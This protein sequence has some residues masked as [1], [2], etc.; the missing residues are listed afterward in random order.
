MTYHAYS[1]I[2]LLPYSS[3]DDI[4]ADNLAELRDLGF[5]MA[6]EIQNVHGKRYRYGEGDQILYARVQQL[7]DNAINERAKRVGIRL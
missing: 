2:I 1:Q 5:S 7:R 4:V 6:K 3:G